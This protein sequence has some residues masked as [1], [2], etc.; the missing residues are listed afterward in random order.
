VKSD[1]QAAR[2]V[3]GLIDAA[4]GLREAHR[5]ADVEL[6]ASEGLPSPAVI[7]ALKVAERRLYAALDA[8]EAAL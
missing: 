8:L 5:R 7:E 1:E 3:E 4:V 6:E 2:A